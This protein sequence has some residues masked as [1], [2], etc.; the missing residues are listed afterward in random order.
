VRSELIRDRCAIVF[1]RGHW[2]LIFILL[3]LLLPGCARL[4]K[5]NPFHK[6]A[7]PP[8]A[9]LAHPTQVIGT[10]VLVSTEGAF[11]LIDT[12]IRPSPTVGATLQT[13][14]EGVSTSQ[15]RVTEV[16][17]RPFIVADIVSGIP[18]K[19]DVVYQ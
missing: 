5:M 13:R 8:K 2:F 17:K 9:E 14:P 11:V 4:Q 16:R 19:G 18:N 10:I 1:Q 3:G 15:L 7:R 6:K 12:G